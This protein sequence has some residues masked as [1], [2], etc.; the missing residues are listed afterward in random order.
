MS[1][2]PGPVPQRLSFA[3][4]AAAGNRPV[5]K[6][7]L[8]ESTNQN[9]K[10]QKHAPSQHGGSGVPLVAP[11]KSPPNGFHGQQNGHAKTNGSTS[12]VEHITS[13]LQNV[14]LDPHVSAAA[15]SGSNSNK[16]TLLKQESSDARS[17][18]SR[19]TILLDEKESLRPDD[20]ASMQAAT[21][22]DGFTPPESEIAG[23][24]K[25]L[26]LERAFGNQ[27]HVIHETENSRMV[28]QRA[29]LERPAG[30]ITNSNALPASAT[31]P[32]AE[33]YQVTSSSAPRM[34]PDPSP[35][36]V[37]PPD[38]KLLE[39]LASPKDR[40][41]VLKIE[42]DM[43]DFVKDP[44]E[45]EL[46]LPQT[47]SFYRML[48]HKLAEYYFLGHVYDETS[49]SVRI[50]RQ[51]YSRTPPP[52]AGYDM[53]TPGPTPPLS[54]TRQIMQRGSKHTGSRENDV[55]NGAVAIPQNWSE[56]GGDG[57][58]QNNSDEGKE[59]LVD[60]KDKTNLTREQ[61]EKRYNEARERIF[62]AAPKTL[63]ADENGTAANEATT[64]VSRSS[65]SSGVKKNRRQKKPKDDS[66][67]AR[68]AYQLHGG[69]AMLQPSQA[70]SPYGTT[71]PAPLSP[72][73]AMNGT[74][75]AFQPN[76]AANYAS[77]SPSSSQQGFLNS[78]PWATS[79]AFGQNMYGSS[80][81]VAAQYSPMQFGNASPMQPHNTPGAN[82]ASQATPKAR[83]PPLATYGQP[84]QTQHLQDQ[85]NWS[86][87]GYGYGYA[88]QMPFGDPSMSAA[89][90]NMNPMVYG[91]QYGVPNG[92][93]QAGLNNYAPISPAAYGNAPPHYNPQAQSFVPQMPQQPQPSTPNQVNPTNGWFS[94]PP[95]PPLQRQ[96]SNN[97][98][99]SSHTPAQFAPSPARQVVPSPAHR[100]PGGRAS[101]QSNQSS[102][103]KF[104]SQQAS[105]PAK[106]PP[107]SSSLSFQPPK[108]SSD[109][110]QPL[111]VNP[112]AGAG[113]ENG[114]RGHA[115]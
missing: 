106:P 14:A 22:G 51:P 42:Q 48:S 65:S 52:L 23:Q 1:R 83:N 37:T 30:F 60:G 90:Q 97:S 41:F 82:Y 84:T 71:Y 43:I 114:K 91:M 47:N 110:T 55:V 31:A 102:I 19:H 104:A 93:M 103:A 12:N 57:I 46:Q 53:G 105:L 24:R 85:S 86:Q 18:V 38:D 63:V 36:L 94:S 49:T 95:P 72:F 89:N 80:A 74:A 8:P 66:F 88:Q 33:T 98:F 70:P 92:F 75:P 76:Y 5:Q 67:Q 50:Y 4:V 56:D 78:N 20:S 58:A 40:L 77:M 96:M 113:L 44:K 79:D 6:P 35:G 54:S 45:T 111:P 3:Q 9:E 69:H 81:S 28:A 27:I 107:T 101:N 112:L 26:E 10:S 87:M 39:A 25:E 15:K 100:P 59:D 108:Y 64:G 21:E 115:E 61:R 62:K 13:A 109:K 29:L 73:A 17:S 7:K 16:A 68:S 99:A 34:D 11:P 2:N 32:A